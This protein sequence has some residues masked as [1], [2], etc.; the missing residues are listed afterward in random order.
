MGYSYVTTCTVCEYSQS[1][2]S[3]KKKGSNIVKR[4]LVCNVCKTISEHEIGTYEEVP[5]TNGEKYHTVPYKKL[6]ICFPCGNSDFKEWDGTS[7]PKCDSP[8]SESK[9]NYLSWIG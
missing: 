8:F 7:C 2:G 5:G 1:I 3:T 4:N 9:E 6:P